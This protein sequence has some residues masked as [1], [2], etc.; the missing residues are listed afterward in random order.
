M[1]NSK[2]PIETGH[3]TSEQVVYR[4]RHHWA[5][6]LGPLFTIFIGALMAGSRLSQA[7]IVFA[8]GFIWGLFSYL[9]LQKS[10]IV[11]T[12]DRLIFSVGFPLKR[13]YDINLND[14][15]IFDFY[16]P[17]LGA[18]LNFGKIILVYEGKKKIAFRFIARPAVLVKEVHEQATAIRRRK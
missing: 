12:K 5:V 2:N 15:T 10:E 13:F 18:M 7:A 3:Y 8:F 17:S 1:N 6:L 14:I 4:T 11:L 9:S 16:Q